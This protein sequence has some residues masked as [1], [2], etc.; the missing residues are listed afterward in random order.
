MIFKDYYKILGI[1]TTRVSIDEI[2]LA[3]R[4]VAKKYHPDVNVGDTLAE[5]RIKDINEAYRILANPQTKKK[6]D[7]IWN[8]NVHKKKRAFSESDRQAGS[9]FSDFFYMFFGNIE[10]KETKNN[11]KLVPIKGENIETSI[12]IDISEAFFGI[13]KQICIKNTNGKRK[14]YNIKVPA[15][16]QTGEKIRLVGQ[17]KAGEN[18][19][20]NGDL[21]IK[22]KIK[23]N[24]RFI[25]KGQDLYTDL[26]L[27][28]W[29]AILGTKAIISSIDEDVTI[30]I[31][32]GIQTGEK[33]RIPGKGY[34]KMQGERGDLVAEIKIMVPK[35]LTKEE[36]I[37]FEKLNEIS[38]FNPRNSYK[39]EKN[40]IKKVDKINAI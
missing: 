7:R 36:K 31:P 14:T 28:P 18:G 2:K 10:E 4:A 23:N 6:Y 11:K 26:P 3:Y 38:S 17:G 27:T 35:K 24:G 12:N 19:G 8:A 37:I 21:F 9:I 40:N 20:N 5:E 30:Y 22:I 29:E 15:G 16:I 13:E 32:A 1:E 34:K 39:E 33:I 25:I